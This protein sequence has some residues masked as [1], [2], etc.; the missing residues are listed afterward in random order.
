MAGGPAVWDVL[1]E[2][3][4]GTTQDLTKA[5]LRRAVVLLSV[6]TVLEMSME[7]LFAVVD[8]FFVSRLGSTPVAA[9]G[10]TESMLSV[11]YAMAMGLGAG[12][13]AVIARRI[14]EKDPEAAANAAVQVLLF[15]LAASAA[16]GVFGAW[17]APSLL[18]AMGATR[19]VVEVGGP[20][21]AILFGGN[22]TITLLFVVNAVCRSAG[23]ASV[24][25]RALW[26][27]SLLNLVLAPCL[28]FGVRPFPGLGVT[29]A[30]V[31]TTLSRGL[32][33]GYASYVL[34]S[35]RGRLRLARRHLTIRVA[36]M[37]EIV[38]LAVPA[39]MQV[40]IETSSWM[41]IVRTIAS[42]GDVALAAY[43]IAMRVAIFALNPPWG[44]A[45]A[46]AT[47]VGQNLGAGEPERARR[48][49]VTIARTNV[50]FLGGA[51]LL[52]L[53]FA[54]PIVGIFASDEAVVV[55]AVSALRIVALSF[56][57]FAYGMVA[58]QAFN[59]AGDTRT[60]MLVNVGAFW[61][62]KLPLAWCLAHAAGL[63]PSGV[64]VAIAAAYT[65]QAVVAAILFRRGRWRSASA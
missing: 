12:A 7:S 26:L 43:T 57:C 15:A 49:V 9:V 8:I 53:V 54:R 3:L 61:F 6:P 47:L 4:R 28:I 55:A 37:R 2:A 65:L 13:T 63:G 34:F 31:A 56:A 58:I 19:E 11:V 62:F 20:Y 38:R 27:A 24:A 64:Y 18:R 40:L 1:R 48:A 32:G 29:G 59:G 39:T 22:V 25:M 35:G 51:G 10:L 52:F 41:G 21:A 50:A 5:P 16:L 14:G 45:N 17:F 36:E 60:P 46:A 33:A 42:F 44:L 23:D 30:A